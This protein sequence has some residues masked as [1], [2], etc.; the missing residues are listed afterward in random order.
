MS[1]RLKMFCLMVFF[2]LVM[3]MVA[4]QLVSEA[5][6]SAGLW[7]LLLVVPLSSSF[8]LQQRE[9][10]FPVLVGVSGIWST[11]PLPFVDRISIGIA[12]SVGLAIVLVAGRGSGARLPR[13]WRGP[14]LVFAGLFCILILR[15][16]IDRPGSARL[17]DSGGMGEALILGSSSI[18]FWVA[19]VSVQWIR[20]WKVAWRRMLIT[21]MVAWG[22]ETAALFFDP[23]KHVDRAVPLYFL[24]IVPVWLLCGMFEAWWLDRKS[25]QEVAR[26]DRIAVPLWWGELPILLTPILLSATSPHRSWPLLALGITLTAC[27]LYRRFWKALFLIVPVIGLL[28]AVVLWVGTENLPLSSRRALSIVSPK[29]ARGLKEDVETGWRSDFRIAMHKMSWARIKQNPLVGAGFRFELSEMDSL[30]P[31]TGVD[32]TGTGLERLAL[33]GG[34]HNSVIQVATTCGIPA[35]ALFVLGLGIVVVRYGVLVRSLPASAEKRFL[36]AVAGYSVALIGTMVVNG[37]GLQFAMV[38]AMTGGMH[39]MLCA[40]SAGTKAKMDDGTKD[41]NPTNG[42][43]SRGD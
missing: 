24:F 4:V 28:V 39:G 13:V 27:L 42:S 30:I 41:G 20:D 25:G 29:F 38:C 7:S 18:M 17:G 11:V 40:H 21:G 16:A 10:W 12:G 5:W 1:E 6:I 34:Y 36:A 33:S 35:A 37:L 8:A 14:G 2:S 43:S 23:R 15:I 22:V 32:P 26:A 9:A 31:W 3:V 19:A